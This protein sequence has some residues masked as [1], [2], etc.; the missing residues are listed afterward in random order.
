[1]PNHILQVSAIFSNSDVL[2]PYIKSGDVMEVAGNRF[3]CA[4][5][6]YA[7]MTR[8]DSTFT[9][10]WNE[11]FNKL[12]KSGAFKNICDDV[13][14]LHGTFYIFDFFTFDMEHLCIFFSQEIQTLINN[15]DM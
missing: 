4:D 1:M 13:Q 8:K 15:Y 3:R 14:K 7:V 12:K 6:G 2:A 11:G 10:I 5:D 9:T